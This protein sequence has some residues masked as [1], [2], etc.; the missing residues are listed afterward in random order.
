M[1]VCFTATATLM[2]VFMCKESIWTSKG[3][4]RDNGNAIHVVSISLGNGNWTVIGQ[5]LSGQKEEDVE[6]ICSGDTENSDSADIMQSNH[7]VSPGFQL[8]GKGK[9][10]IKSKDKCQNLELHLKIIRNNHY[11]DKGETG[12]SVV[13]EGYV[14]G[15]LTKKIIEKT[16]IDKECDFNTTT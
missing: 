16:N 15:K 6:I 10:I 5:C 14:N 8:K 3:R 1:I 2:T 11:M 7:I 12:T 9:I 13:L 4:D